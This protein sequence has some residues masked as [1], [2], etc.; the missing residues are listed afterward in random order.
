MNEEGYQIAL[1][2]IQAIIV[3]QNDLLKIPLDPD[4]LPKVKA[5]EDFPEEFLDLSGLGLKEIPNELSNIKNLCELDLSNNRLITL[6]EWFVQMA[7]LKLLDLRNNNLDSLPEWLQ[8]FE[9]FKNLD[10]RRYPRDE[11]EIKIPILHFGKEKYD[12]QVFRG[13]MFIY[14]NPIAEKHN[15]PEEKG[16][17]INEIANKNLPIDSLSLPPRTRIV[18]PRRVRVFISYSHKDI[19]YREKCETWLKALKKTCNLDL[20]FWSDRKIFVGDDWLN[21][22]RREL[23]SANVVLY[24]VSVDFLASDFIQAEEMIPIF[25]K[26]E[27][28]KD[29]M[30]VFSILLKKCNHFFDSELARFQAV[31]ESGKPISM[32]K[33][34]DDGW[35]NAFT[36]IKASVK[37]KFNQPL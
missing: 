13:G 5:G 18:P 7:G 32:F 35:D 6:P 28:S 14:G 16:E 34:R 19:K 26:L 3:K 20:V 2:K 15:I 1:T 33:P 25:N 10:F 23:M 17:L 9:A 21:V 37:N 29:S 36:L 27:N 12:R 31:P 11:I 22:I 8:T 30:L 4:K 24:L